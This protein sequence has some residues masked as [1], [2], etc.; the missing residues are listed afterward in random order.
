MT[1]ERYA[2]LQI[3]FLEALDLPSEARGQLLARCED[4][5][6]RAL[7]EEML[8]ID[9]RSEATGSLD[10]LQLP[11]DTIAK[12]F[13]DEAVDGGWRRED[14]PTRNLTGAVIDGR[15]MVEDMIGQGGMGAVY[16]ARHEL[17][18]DKVAIKVLH[19]SIAV[20]SDAWDRLFDEGRLLTR[21]RHPNAV[22]VR[23]LA[24][25]E[26]GS[27]YLVLDYVEGRTLRDVLAGG[28]LRREVAFEVL[29]QVAEA[30]EAAHTAGIVHCDLKPENIMVRERANGLDATVLDFGIARVL[31]PPEGD[32]RPDGSGV[33]GT[34]AYMAPEQMRVTTADGRSD[35]DGRADVF[36]LAIVF[37]EMIAGVSPFE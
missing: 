26:D 36:S 35:V 10:S 4:P 31:R 8:E 28:P 16:R 18:R 2:R 23:D 9:S 7:L 30:V 32:P 3:L 6:D 24:V 29:R 27:P 11:L 37:S 34:P 13:A 22:R 21:F 1:P 25:D 5:A 20:W 15:Y 12:L 19:R 14:L 17:L 33:A